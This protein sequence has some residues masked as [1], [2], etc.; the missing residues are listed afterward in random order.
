MVR[1]L[2][3]NHLIS[4][5]CSM[6]PALC[7]MRLLT[8]QPHHKSTQQSYQNHRILQLRPAKKSQ[9]KK[10][11][12][13]NHPVYDIEQPA[14]HFVGIIKFVKGTYVPKFVSQQTVQRFPVGFF[15][16]SIVGLNGLPVFQSAVVG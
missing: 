1:Q 16:G 11:F 8:S 14:E 10:L 2:A 9:I 12:I 4:T 3:E 7:A 13:F 5:L 15:V 6:R